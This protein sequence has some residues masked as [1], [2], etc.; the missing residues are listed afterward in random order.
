MFPELSSVNFLPFFISAVSGVALSGLI[1]AIVLLRVRQHYQNNLFSVEQKFQEKLQQQFQQQQL[2]EQEAQFSVQT[3]DNTLKRYE[4]QLSEIKHQLQEMTHLR[5]VAEQKLAAVT[6]REQHLIV[7]KKTSETLQHQLHDTKEALARAHEQQQA[8][9]THY[10]EQLQTLSDAKKQLTQ[11]FENLAN[12]IFERKQSQFNE[13]SQTALNTTIDP[14]K[15]QLQEFRKRVD[16]V[17]DKENAERNRLVGHIQQLQKQTEKIGND[18]INLANA[19]KGDNKL[20]GNWGEVILERLLEDSGLQKGREYLVQPSLKDESGARRSPDVIVRLPEGKDIVIDSKVSLADYER[21][22]SAEEEHLKKAALQAHVNS[23]RQHVKSLSKKSYQHLE[24]LRSLDFVFIFVP[25]EAAFLLALQASPELF[26]EAYD[27]HIVLVSP[28][29]LLATLRTV[30][31][32]WRY[33]KQNTNAEE[34]AKSAGGLY[35]QF[36]LVLESLDL[37]GVA[38][39]KSQQ[40]FEQTHKRLSSGRGNLLRRVEGLQKLGAKT[41]KQLPQ[42]YQ[43]NDSASLEESEHTVFVNAD[44][45]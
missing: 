33:E 40:A 23:M 31:N 44:D 45:V 42:R 12:R 26:K 43:V 22:F 11:E 38:L 14:L 29:T 5:G 9:E 41:K 13:V 27:H 2:D 7:Y 32:I 15:Q 37:L 25:I 39:E 28:T 36:V 19:L 34:I 16:D 4:Q 10:Q 6:E 18:A 3:L 35:D 24:G 8:R 21:Y 17:Y 20:Q 30:E 1:A